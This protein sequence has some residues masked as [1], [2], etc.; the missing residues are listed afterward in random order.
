MHLHHLT[1]WLERQTRTLTAV[2]GLIGSDV[3]SSLNQKSRGRPDL[4]SAMTASGFIFIGVIGWINLKTGHGL[5]FEFF[6]LLGCVFVGWVAGT[7]AALFCTA[8]SGIFLC[9]AETAGSEL[10]PGWIFVWN[11]LVRLL[12][13][14]VIG[15]LA[16][17]VGKSTRGLEQTVQQRTARLQE[18]VKEHKE[19]ADLLHEALELFK[20][21]TENI[22]DVFWV[23]DPSKSEVH[24]VSPEFEKVWGESRQSLYVSPNTWLEGIHPEDRERV[25]RTTLTKQVMGEFDE[26][27]RVVRPDGSLRWV[28]DRAFPVKNQDGSVYRL[29][30]IAEDITERNRTEQLVQAQRDVGVS[31]S[32][33]S[34]LRF[35][36]DRLLEIAVQLEGIDCGGIYLMDQ[37]TGE[38]NLEAHRG[39]SG[40]FI[41]RVSH[42]K[43]DATETRLVKAGEIVYVRHE[44]IPRSLEVLWGSEGL[45]ALAVVPVQHKGVVLG[46]LNLGSYREDEIPQKT[47]VGIEMLASQ[48]AGA[49]ARIRAEELLRRSE[50]HLRTIIRTAPIALFAGDSNGIVTFEDG[51]ALGAVGVRPGENVGRSATDAYRRFPLLAEN[52]S[53]ALA[54]E[55]FSA[56]LELGPT[57]LECHYTPT[58]DSSANIT[59]FLGVATNVT[60]R[61]RLERQIL[62]I[63][64]RE[65]ARIGQDIHD[66]LCQQLVSI[67]FDANSLERSLSSEQRAETSVAHRIT[68]QLDEAITESRRVSRGLYPVRLETDGL[69]PALKELA[70][71]TTERFKVHCLCQAVS[72]GPVCDD[73]TAIHLYRI[74][75]EAVNNALKHS[76][77]SNVSIQLAESNGRI[78]LTVQDDGKGIEPRSGKSTGMGLHTM[79][80]RARSMGGN[81]RVFRRN[82]NGTVVVCHVSRKTN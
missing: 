82:P 42:Y 8:I 6:Y 2:V 44:Q 1:Q 72:P 75:Q 32:S 27:Y 16:A 69:V 79:D 13:F 71:K 7:R 53:R 54:G 37:A 26:E 67:A 31:L 4:A 30:G 47:R 10:Q 59:G 28:H 50:A 49:I 63:S 40:S 22:T 57:V 55:E 68:A 80:Y 64:D 65:Q 48:A 46:M 56:V 11:T 17:Q 52:I 15:W 3:V 76:G 74:A 39:L 14:A 20:Q 73:A 58:R 81:L 18:E 25:A 33:T 35:A 78:E 9:L 61:F 21:V 34:D 41:K 43:A 38:L 29:V 12:A 60:E 5:N 23:T 70:D 62:E 77:A 24:Y 36:L 19:T 45:R 66:G 51:Q